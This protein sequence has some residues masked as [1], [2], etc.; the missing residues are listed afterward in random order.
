MINLGFVNDVE[1][2][3]FSSAFLGIVNIENAGRE[4]QRV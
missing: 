1:L 2:I 4:P 3:T